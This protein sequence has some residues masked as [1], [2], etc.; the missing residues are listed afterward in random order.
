MHGRHGVAPTVVAVVCALTAPAASA[1]PNEVSIHDIQGTTRISPLDGERVASVEGVVTGVRTSGAPGFWIQEPHPDGDPRTSEGLFVYTGDQ[2]PDVRP[3]RTVSVSGTVTEYY[4]LS[5]DETPDNTADQ[6][7]TEITDARWRIVGSAPI[8]APETLHPWT[9]PADHAPDAGG[10]NIE[11]LEL[12]PGR[13]ALDFYESREGMNLRVEEARVVGATDEYDALWVT[14]K[15]AQNANERGGTTYTSYDDPNTGRLKIESLAAGAFPRA[16]VGDRLL[17][18]TAGPLD[19]TR[20]GGY[21]LQARGLGELVDGGTRRETTRPQTPGELA[22]ATYNVENL[23]AT[24]D[25]AKF[26]RLARGIVSRLAEPDIVALEEVQDDNGDTDNGVVAADRTLRRLTDAIA[27]AGGPRYEW[28]QINPVDGADGGEP[29]G[30][31]RVAFLFNPDRVSFVDRPGGDATT[32]VRVVDGSGGSGDSEAAL[33]V[34][35]GRV[36]PTDPAFTDSRKPLVGEFVFR[37]RTVFVVANHFNSKGGDQ[38]L[39][40]RFQPPTRSSEQQRTEQA[41]VV[42][43]FVD[44][45]HRVDPQARVAVVGDLND[46]GF[47][48]TLDILTSPDGLRALSARLPAVE[49]YSYVYDGNSQLLDHVLVSEAIREVDYDIVHTNAEFANAVSDHD[50]QVARLDLT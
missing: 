21:V 46:F 23:A 43:E 19:Y 40:G 35:P 2:A 32:P 4:P 12:R 24:D 34:S 10:G 5:W 17:G 22:V 8:P 36:R 6:S 13:H 45:I 39:H 18:T 11:K 49:R 7:I 29:G 44:R 27:A 1:A 42:R 20:F 48:P 15:P 50:P 30:N 3:G 16:D 38:P 47:S 33:N 9:V 41:R 37:G 26:E 14:T 25:A 28:R 31:I